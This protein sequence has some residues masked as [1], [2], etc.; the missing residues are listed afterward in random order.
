[1]FFHLCISSTQHGAWNIIIPN[2]NVGST[3]IKTI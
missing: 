2:K 3:E 1:M